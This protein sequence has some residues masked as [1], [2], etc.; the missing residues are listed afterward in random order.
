MIFLA[1]KF[2][3]KIVLILRILV[4]IILIVF[5]TIDL[6]KAIMKDG[7][8]GK[9]VKKFVFRLLG[10]VL[11]FFLPTLV[12]VVFN[13]VNGFDSAKKENSLCFNCILDVRKCN[14]NTGGGGGH[15]N[16]STADVK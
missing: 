3:G 1:L 16:V 14:S 13:L 8:I 2:I 9:V 10:G 6:S 5:G 12:L 4:P 15:G 7:E 11:I